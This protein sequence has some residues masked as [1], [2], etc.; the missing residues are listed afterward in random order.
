MATTPTAVGTRRAV[1]QIDPAHTEVGF[2][3]RHLM[4]STVK[5][6]FTAVEGSVS[7]EGD[8]VETARV[9]VK[10]D[11]SSIDTRV[12]QRDQHLRSPDFLDA[13][14]YPY[15]TFE[16]TKVERVG[17]DR[18]KIVGD[19]TIRDTTR[20]VSLDAQELGRVK[21][22]WGSERAGFTATTEINR[23]DFGLNWNQA[24]E[25][26]GVLVGDRVSITLET[27]LVLQ[28]ED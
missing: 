10:I 19:L 7:I 28:S 20:E 9:D 1:W 5:G 17:E 3:V 11:A 27:E 22:P 8:D 16:S 2:G 14:T 12:E 25:T 4:I 23:R 6:N 21:D 15:L 26:G 24:L 13:E 18:L